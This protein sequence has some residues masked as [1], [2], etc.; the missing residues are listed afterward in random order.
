VSPGNITPYKIT[1]YPANV[2]ERERSK[3]MALLD[4]SGL[5]CISY[6]LEKKTYID[7][8]DIHNIYNKII[9]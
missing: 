1:T 8:L 6:V 4:F 7:T 5:K 9:Y 2:A 3:E